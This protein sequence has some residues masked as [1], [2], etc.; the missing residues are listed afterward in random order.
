MEFIADFHIHS[1]YSRATSR[2]MDIEHIAERAR[3]KGMT[4]MG[5]GDFTHHLWLEELKRNLEDLGNGLFKYRGIYFML[6]TEISSIYSKNGRGYRIHNIIFAPSF[7][8]VDKINNTLSRWGNLASDGRPILG[9]DAQELARIIFDIDENCFFVPAHIWTPWFSVFGSMSGFDRIE[10]CFEE[11]SSK[12]FALETGLSCYDEKTEVLTEDGWK[13]FS[14]VKYSDKICT[15]N[16]K[17]DEIEFQIPTKIYTYRY[18]G[19]M[20]R[21]KTKRVD[22]LVTPNHKLLYSHCDFRK[23]PKFSLKEA[24]LLFNKSKRF[25]KDGIWVGEGPKHFILPAVRMRYGSRHYSG[26]RNKREKKLPM[27]SWLKF[28]GFWL[29]EGWTSESNDGEYNVCVCNSNKRLLFEIRQILESFGYRTYQRENIVRVRNYQL[30]HY[31]KQFGKCYDK[32]IPSGIKSLS[33]ELLEILLQYYLKGDGHVYGRNNKGL[34]A[35]TTSIR[36]RDD[37]QEIALKIGI[38]A[39]YKL[40]YK[41]GKIFISP[42]CKK[43]Y[44]Q[45]NDSWIIFFIRQNR[46]ITLPST[47]KKHNYTERWMEYKGL[48]F[49]VSVP[50]HVIY[51]RRNSIPLWCGNSDPPMNWRLSALDKYS[52]ISNSDSHSP[53][54]IGREANVFNCELSYKGIIDTL[55]SKDKSRFLYTIEFF[56]QE[57]KYYFDGHRACGVRFSPKETKENKGRCPKCGK[58]ITV[59]VMN[60]VE[61]LSDRPEGYAPDNA[62]PYKNL[63]PLD[64]IIAEVKGIGK[65]SK[66]VE[67]EYRMAI[68]KFGSEFEILLRAKREDLEENLPKRLAEGIL[69]IHQGQVIVQ[70]GFDG[71]YGK[72]SIFSEEEKQVKGEQQLSLF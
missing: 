66:A 43:L 68:S 28:F 72:I 16:L 50:N 33:R 49:C 36:L 14:E 13:K 1:K 59:G 55:K 30:F 27:E 21:L 10:D 39:Y 17:T 53:A 62:I 63:I 54:K 58:P 56:P 48:V 9:M 45:R 64:E 18:K 5:T 37:L 7:K 42:G 31:L 40:G 69:R 29:A 4:L 23:Q 71:E 70:P 65:T 44:K 46:P 57:G 20:Y 51:I 35:T 22:L 3:L 24:E 32:F 67:A 47:I 6:T 38:S 34:S 8:T 60:R 15:L 2:D 41:K 26:F 19:K 11:Q 12:I 61:Q 25:K 52:L